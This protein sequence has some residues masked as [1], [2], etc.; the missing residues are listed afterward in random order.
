MFLFVWDLMWYI[1]QNISKKH[2]AQESNRLCW[3]CS[4]IRETT[5]ALGCYVQTIEVI[6]FRLGSIPSGTCEMLSLL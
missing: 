4:T 1:M 3:V 5:A 6:F 2:N